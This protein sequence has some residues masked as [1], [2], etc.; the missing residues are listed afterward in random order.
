M[1]LQSSVGNFQTYINWS[2]LGYFIWN[3]PLMNAT[4][5]C[6]WL[7]NFCSS[8]GFVPLGN[9]PLPEGWP[10]SILPYDLI[11]P[12]WINILSPEQGSKFHSSDC[13]R[14]V[15]NNSRTSGMPARRVRRTTAHFWFS[16][17]LHWLYMF[18]TSECYIWT[19]DFYNPLAWRTSAFNSKF[20]SL[21]K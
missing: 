20:Q 9:K 21:L 19:N 17:K 7:I 6:W 5:P 13:L 15:T 2:Y 16:H 1:Q 11:T 12:Q 14:W 10:R 8:N 4:R 3:C 18:Q